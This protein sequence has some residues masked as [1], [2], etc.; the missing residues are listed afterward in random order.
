M[1][2]SSSSV[3]LEEGEVPIELLFHYVARKLS[4]ASKK[5]NPLHLVQERWERKKERERGT[6]SRREER[7]GER[8]EKERRNEIE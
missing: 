3:L 2:L 1:A 8:R 5:S 7:E 6:E 4:E